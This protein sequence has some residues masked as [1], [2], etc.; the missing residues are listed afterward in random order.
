M[1]YKRYIPSRYTKGV[2]TTFLVVLVN[3]ISKMEY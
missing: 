3:G 2:V 1:V